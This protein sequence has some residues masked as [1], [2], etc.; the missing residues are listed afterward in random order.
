M[1]AELTEDD[2]SKWIMNEYDNASSSRDTILQHG[3]YSL[4]S[5]FITSTV[6]S[7]DKTSKLQTVMRNRASELE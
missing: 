3:V 6:N 2:V 1:F 7:L 4:L 5:V